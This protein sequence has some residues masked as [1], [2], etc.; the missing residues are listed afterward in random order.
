[1]V[2]RDLLGLIGTLIE[3]IFPAVFLLVNFVLS[4]PIL[5]ALVSKVSFELTEDELKL[6]FLEPTSPC[7]LHRRE[8]PCLAFG[9]F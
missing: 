6:L 3:L 8:P 4:L 9:V 2:M 7:W 5:S 1:M